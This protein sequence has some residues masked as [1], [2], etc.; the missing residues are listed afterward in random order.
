[1][2]PKR[3][4]GSPGDDFLQLDLLRATVPVCLALGSQSGDETHVELFTLDI[5]GPTR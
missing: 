4:A 5:F 2:I 1:M 3:A